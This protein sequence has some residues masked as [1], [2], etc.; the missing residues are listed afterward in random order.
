VVLGVSTGAV[1]KAVGVDG[2]GKFGFGAEDFGCGDEIPGLGGEDVDGEQVEVVGAVALKSRAAVAEAAEVAS[3]FASGKALDLHAEQVAAVFDYKVI[4]EVVAPGF[5]DAISVER[6]GGH[7]LQFD[8]LSALL[9]IFELLPELL[10]V[11]IAHPCDR[12]LAPSFINA[13]REIPRPVGESTGLRD[14]AVKK[15]LA[16]FFN[17]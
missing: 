6:G 7:E 9:E 13:A 15:L 10:L 11:P 17:E 4:F 14:D 2:D 5:E 16:A 1:R 12:P 3:A 8:P